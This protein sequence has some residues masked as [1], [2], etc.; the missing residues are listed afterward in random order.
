M[1]RDLA[2]AALGWA[3]AAAFWLGATRLQRSLLS[4]EF[5]ADGLP[6]DGKN[7]LSAACRALSRWSTVSPSIGWVHRGPGAADT[8]DTGVTSPFTTVIR[9]W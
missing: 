6:K 9:I 7:S 2:C 5:G 3:L 4:D 8:T 1:L